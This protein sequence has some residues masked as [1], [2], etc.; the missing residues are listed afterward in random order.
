MAVDNG[1]PP[2]SATRDVQ[3][4]VVA[5]NNPPVLADIPPQMV[6]EGGSLN[7]SVSATDADGTIPTLWATKIPANASF[8]DNGDG[9][10]VFTFD[11]GFTQSGL[12]AVEFH[13]SDGIESTK[14]NA[15]IQVIDAGNQRPVVFFIGDQQTTENVLLEFDMS[16]D[17]PDSTIPSLAAD[18]LPGGATFVDNGDGTG[19]FSWLPNFT[20]SGDYYVNFIAS[21]G[22]LAD[23]EV[24]Y[25]QVLPGPAQPPMIDSTYVVSAQETQTAFFKVY[26]SDID[27]VPPIL[28]TSALPGGTFTDNGDYTGTYQW[29]TTYDDSGT[30]NVRVYAND[31]DSADLIDSVDITFTVSNLNRTPIVRFPGAQESNVNEGDTLVFTVQGLDY[32]G[33]IPILTITPDS[34]P[35][36]TF[37]DDSAGTGTLTITPDYTQA[38]NYSIKFTAT[39]GARDTLGN[40]VYPDAFD[41]LTQQF[42][43]L[44]V[45]VGPILDP[46]GP[47]TMTEGDTLDFNVHATHPGGE[48]MQIFAEN[49]PP[50]MTMAGFADTRFVNFRPDYTQSGVYTVLFYVTDATGDADSEYVQITVIEAGNQ[51]PYFLSTMPDTQVIAYG[52]SIYNRVAAVDPDLDPITLTLLT[53]PANASFVDSGNGSGS[54]KFVPDQTQY[55]QTFNF[56][57]VATDTAGLAD[58]LSKFVRV[59]AFMRGDSNSDGSVDISDI[60]F[61]VS[62]IFR[63]GPAPVS[64]DVADAN[65]DQRVDISD[66]LY[67]VNYIFRSGPPPGD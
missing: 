22:D 12:Y 31:P 61:I 42:T 45:N 54:V 65:S 18:P 37:V 40:L 59:V 39:D 41:T 17:D 25:I 33:D 15:L 7:F 30:Y 44:N 46:I 47:K 34:I 60:T 36:F 16:A 3:I 11:P 66:A 52:D 32:D 5:T 10:G 67:L 26:T 14:K 53:P 57:V 8:V 51:S 62:Y 20:Q 21:D 4:T 48:S 43:V 55:W 24:V 27:S 13:A 38:R 9:T 49:M 64:D 2:M 28:T 29:A 56:R 50:N 6:T 58:T 63:G 19:S 1:T 35:N 23:T